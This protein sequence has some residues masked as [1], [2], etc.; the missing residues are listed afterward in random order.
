MRV[1]NVRATICPLYG[2]VIAIGAFEITHA[3]SVHDSL[4]SCELLFRSEDR[5]TILTPQLQVFV[6]I[7]IMMSALLLKSKDFFTSFVFANEVWFSIDMN[8]LML[9]KSVFSNRRVIAV[10]TLQYRLGARADFVG[11]I[12]MIEEWVLRISA[13]IASFLN[14]VVPFRFS[15]FRAHVIF[16]SGGEIERFAANAANVGCRFL[17]RGFPAIFSIRRPL[18]YARSGV[19][20]LLVTSPPFVKSE[21][22]ATFPAR[23]QSSLGH[24]L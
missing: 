10:L 20:S 22:F 2:R 16:E 6:T 8:Q 5:R 23:E 21:L 12:H 7:P 3:M 19:T 17:F 4:V 13:K 14:T 1:L 9:Q 24:R 18:N 15:M 11:R